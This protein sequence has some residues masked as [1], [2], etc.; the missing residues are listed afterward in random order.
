MTE[1]EAVRR[2]AQMIVSTSI[3]DAPVLLWLRMWVYR[4]FYTIGTG[5]TLARA[6]TFIR[7]HG[8]RSGFV[9]IGNDV[10]INHHAE[11][12]YS[13]GVTIE[14][15]VWISQYVMI[16][17]HE[18]TITGRRRKKDQGIETS[19]LLVCQ[20]A[21][22]G[23]FVVILPQVQRIGEGAIVAAGAVVTHDVG[24][25]EIVGG[26]PARVIGRRGI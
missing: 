4:R 25:W 13:G 11:I 17:T 1:S 8:L 12:D 16:E 6:V 3:F 18:H 24:D 14:D 21:W 2:A 22:L 9:K 7:P 5:T 15:D 26:V 19:S 23:A 20:D 10:G